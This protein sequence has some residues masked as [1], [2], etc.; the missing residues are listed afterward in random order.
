MKTKVC[1][2]CGIKKPVS[3]FYK[4][5]SYYGGGPR[6]KCKQCT[7]KKK[8]S[9]NVTPPIPEEF[10]TCT[11]CGETKP[12]SEYPVDRYKSSGY[13]PSCKDCRNKHRRDNRARLSIQEK[14]YWENN[15][16]KLQAKRRRRS[17]RKYGLSYE[18]YEA[19]LKSE[20]EICGA[21][22]DLS[23]DHNHETNEVR[24]VLCRRCNLCIGRM[25]DDPGILL[26]A[27]E[28]L[29]RVGTYSKKS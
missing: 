29:Q 21:K 23:V 28:Y 1:T 17:A 20:C 5:T 11:K 7:N 15:P 9:I 27:V 22:E 4:K 25:D 26:R 10:R 19:A 14:K 24:G 2:G 12:I 3:E 6:S 16:E 13:S 18:E 8:Y